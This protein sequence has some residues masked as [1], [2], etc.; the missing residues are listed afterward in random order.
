MILYRNIELGAYLISYRVLCCYWML[1]VIAA[2]E[3]L[4]LFLEDDLKDAISVEEEVVVLCVEDVLFAVTLVLLRLHLGQDK[5]FA[6][7][8]SLLDH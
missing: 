2:H 1:V 7:L 6:F 3:G 8:K 5:V 4:V